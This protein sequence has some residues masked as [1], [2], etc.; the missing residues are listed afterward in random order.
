MKVNFLFI[1]EHGRV[2]VECSACGDRFFDRLSKGAHPRMLE[3]GI[4]TAIT[5]ANSLHRSTG[6]VIGSRAVERKEAYDA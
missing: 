5:H 2:G 4:S 3:S 6:G 1:E